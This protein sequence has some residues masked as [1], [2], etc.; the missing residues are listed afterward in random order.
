MTVR[1]ARP[2]TSA[3]GLLGPAVLAA[4]AAGAVA[5]VVAGL[6]DGSEGVT[7]ALVGAG[8]VLGFLLV[9]QLPVAQ[10]AR[11]R[12]GV[13]AALL[14]LLY[15]VRVI[16]LLVARRVLSVSDDVHR[17]SVGVTVI[18][19]ALAWTAGTVW[20]ALRWRPLVVEPD[21][22]SEETVQTR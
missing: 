7:G 10:V 2:G 19:C 17:A 12:R 3:R 18:A 4:L 15:T 22:S 1:R 13:G 5:V 21:S 6:V 16:L 20:S 8:L 9:G 14:V 11:G